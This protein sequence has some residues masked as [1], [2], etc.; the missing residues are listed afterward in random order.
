MNVTRS[1]LPRIV[2][3]VVQAQPSGMKHADVVRAIRQMG[4]VG[5]PGF[6]AA[7]Y[8]I[9]SH[10]V[11]CGAIL[12]NEQALERRYRANDCVPCELAGSA[13]CLASEDCPHERNHAGN[14]P[15]LTEEFA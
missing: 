15:L 9:L 10:L 3:K 4:Y 6:S 11:T 2:F 8:E 14:L 12:R 1:A 5:G 7:I 13:L